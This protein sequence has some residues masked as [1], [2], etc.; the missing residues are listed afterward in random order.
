MPVVSDVSVLGTEDLT[1]MKSH[2]EFLKARGVLRQ[3]N[4]ATIYQQRAAFPL[5]PGVESNQFSPALAD[6]IEYL[7]GTVKA[8]LLELSPEDDLPANK[9]SEFMKS[10]KTALAKQVLTLLFEKWR[11]KNC[12]DRA[13]ISE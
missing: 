10:M 11:P 8:A 1:L 6:D 12:Q 2:Y 7:F 13:T 4:L 3:G 5:G 9:K